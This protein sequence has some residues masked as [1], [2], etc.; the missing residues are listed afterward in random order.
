MSG[1]VGQNLGRGSGLVKV[2]AVDADSVT[3]AS[4]AD[5]AI[6]SEHY[7]DA[8][9]DNAHLADN[10][11][12][13]AEIADN[14]ITLAKMA[15]GTDGNIISYDASGD[16]VA[17]AT[18]TDGQVLTSTGA[19]SPPAFEAA[20]AGVFGTNAFKMRNDAAVVVSWSTLTLFRVNNVVHDPDSCCDASDGN[21]KFTAPADGTYFFWADVTMY[22]S[23]SASELGVS[24]YKN[25]ASVGTSGKSFAL[26]LGNHG[27]G[28]HDLYAYGVIH[29][30]WVMTLEADDY[31]QAYISCYAY[32][33]NDG[34]IGYSGNH[35]GGYRIA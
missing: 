8:S 26:Q 17:I 35:F 24:F 15:G 13:T 4:I 21:H 18:G 20:A 23:G 32:N 10:A 12:D 25:G 34:T 6:D 1:I 30:E 9:I 11:A 16:P 3:G 28:T 2:T 7:V 19:G 22:V 33:Q 14:A 31:V 5:D 29:H 27:H